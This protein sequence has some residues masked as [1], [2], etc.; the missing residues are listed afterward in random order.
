V[1]QSAEVKHH[2]DL[3]LFVR[4]DG[5][6]THAVIRRGLGNKM[7]RV[8]T[9]SAEFKQRGKKMDMGLW[10]T[11]LFGLALLVGFGLILVDLLLN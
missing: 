8:K 1:W 9:Q 6:T 4:K 2:P 11:I 5:C 3:F 7:P 10:L